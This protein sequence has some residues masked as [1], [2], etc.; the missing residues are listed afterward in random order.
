LTGVIE[1]PDLAVDP[2]F[3]QREAR[4]VNRAALTAEIER[5]LVQ[6]PAIAWE[7]A[8]NAAGVPAAR[9]L[10]VPQALELPQIVERG[11]VQDFHLEALDRDI[12]LVRAGFKVDGEDPRAPMPP[13]T[14]GQHTDELLGE[15]GYSSDEIAGFHAQ[16]VL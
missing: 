2:R 3:A 1:R 10:T 9:V 14:L 5:A 16:G 6:R 13:P 11:L 15:L 8:L 12:S 7:T 4:K